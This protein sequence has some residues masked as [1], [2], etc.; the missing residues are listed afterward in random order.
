MVEEGDND[1]KIVTYDPSMAEGLAEMFNKFKESWPG[2]FGGGVPFSEERIKDSLDDSSAIEIFI[3]LD[4]DG[5]PVGF[6]DLTP[7]WSDQGAAYVDLLGVIQRVKGK[8]FGKRLLLKAIEKAIQEG[9]ERVDLHTWSGNIDAVPLYKKVGMFWAP[10]TTVYMQDYIPLLHKNDL[11]KEWFELHPDWYGDLKRGLKQEPDGLKVDGMDIYRYRFEAQ[12]DWMEVDIDRY[13]FGITGVRRKIMDEELRVEARVDSHH[14]HTGMDNA[15]SITVENRTGEDMEL[16]VKVKTFEGLKFREDPPQ[17]IT[18]KDGEKKTITREFV[19]DSTS[20]IYVSTHKVSQT[21]DT[22]LDT[23][24]ERFELTTGGKIKPAVE[25]SGAQDI[26]RLSSGEVYLDLKNNTEKALSGGITYVMEGKEGKID[27]ALDAKEVGGVSLP[28]TFLEEGD[29]KYIE[30]TPFI[31]KEDGAFPMK[32]YKHPVVDDRYGMAAL[33]EKEDE[34]YLVN[35]E[36]KV[37]VKLEGGEVLMSEMR[38][39]HELDIELNHSVGPPFGESLDDTLRYEHG[40]VEDEEGL[41]LILKMESVHKPGVILRSHLRLQKHSSE[42][43][44]WLELENGGGE[45]VEVAAKTRTR[46]WMLEQAYHSK[47]KVYTPLGDQLIESDPVTHMLSSTLMPDDPDGWK[48]TWTAYEDIEGAVSGFIWDNCNVKKISLAAGLLSELKSVSRGLKPGERYRCNRLWVSLKK[49]SLDSFRDTWNRLVGRKPIHPNERL[50]GKKR[51]RHLSARLNDN[52]LKAGEENE[53]TISLDKVVDYPLTGECSISADGPLDVSI[54]DRDGPEMKIKVGVPADM[55][56][57]V[58][59]IYLR[60]SGER[61][62]VFDLPV[63][64]MGGGHVRVRRDS[65]EGKDVIYVDNG[66]IRF[67]IVDGIGGNLIRLE[68]SEGNTYFDDSF[69]QVGPKSY[70]ENHMGGIGPRFMTPEDIYSFYELEEVSCQE[71]VEGRWKGVEVEFNIEKMDSLRGQRF[72]IKYLTL[73]G[74]KLIKMVMIHKNPK[75]RL[76]N[77]VG[78]LFMDVLLDGSLEDTVVEVSG[79]YEDWKR[80][81]QNQQFIPPGNIEEP[82]FYFHRGDTS[83][84]GFAVEGSPAL[85]TCLCNQEISMAFMAVEMMSK[86]FEEERV[87]MGLMMDSSRE[88]V[89]VARKALKYME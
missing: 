74:T 48:E 33:V 89:V 83:L 52:I 19:V 39:D 54:L 11:T 38:R 3:A 32:S 40:S 6:C 34:V 28:I 44:S 50:H 42:L 27:F 16:D 30:L 69:P 75:E 47:T 57:C 70:F 46:R 71:T 72:V 15:Y 78:E 24:V 63:I 2:G 35:D 7:H 20:K 36:V 81:Y 41:H 23:G 43:E 26:D 17:S 53:R 29:V 31:D 87:E 65:L 66:K 79:R 73:P 77:W 21:I 86:A 5:V 56:S 14:I 49:P 10:E 22:T 58:G 4:E 59:K 9:I 67:H 60:L 51:K 76:V 61:E 25:V 45:P 80:S 55:E 88:D 84:G 68:N 82:W 13:G 37:K 18:V 12:D 8:R 85:C 64:V 1:G 62:F